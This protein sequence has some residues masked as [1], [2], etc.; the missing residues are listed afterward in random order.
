[1]CTLLGIKDDS[2]LIS[3]MGLAVETRYGRSFKNLN[4][5]SQTKQKQLKRL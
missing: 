4:L 2:N 5:K 1:M 3:V